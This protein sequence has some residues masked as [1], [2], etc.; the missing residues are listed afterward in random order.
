MKDRSFD[1]VTEMTAPWR[2]HALPA[3]SGKCRACITFAAAFVLLSE[4]LLS[5]G[6]HGFQPPPESEKPHTGARAGE[7]YAVPSAGVVPAHVSGGRAALASAATP[8]VASLNIMLRGI[9]A[10]GEGSGYAIIDTGSDEQTISVGREVLPGVVLTAVYR[11]Y[12]LLRRAGKVERVDLEKG[13]QPTSRPQQLAGP[14]AP[15]EHQQ[16][17]DGSD[18]FAPGPAGGLVI[19]NVN[20]GGLSDSLGLEAGDVVLS[21]NGRRLTTPSELTSIYSGLKFGQQVQIQ[22]M[23]GGQRLELSQQALIH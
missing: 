2:S 16:Q 1:V 15:R 14:A 17:D 11:G 3:T 22:V 9:V 19:V 18:R 20:A 8:E 6:A 7:S 4:W 23:R 21:V 13:A 5:P 10:A 12:I